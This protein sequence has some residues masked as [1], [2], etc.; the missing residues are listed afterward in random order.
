V[1]RDAAHPVGVSWFGIFFH[2]IFRK[3]PKNLVEEEK[4]Q[5]CLLFP[6]PT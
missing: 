4:A 1:P 2:Q 5:L 3:F 6:M